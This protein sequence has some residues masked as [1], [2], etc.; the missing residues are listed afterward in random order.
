[1]TYTVKS[2]DTLSKIA[3]AHGVTVDEIVKSNPIIKDPNVIRVGWILNIPDKVVDVAGL[4][5]EC[6]K[7][8]E[9]LPS[10]KKLVGV[11]ND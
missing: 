11:I 8:V 2:G 9:N 1:M 4:L 3:K 6:V 5:K 7:D 10:F